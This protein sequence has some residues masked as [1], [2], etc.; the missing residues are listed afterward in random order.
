[1]LDV[2]GGLYPL[3]AAGHLPHN[4]A[5]RGKAERGIAPQPAAATF[6]PQAGRR[7]MPR[8]LAPSSGR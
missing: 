6:S 3:W 8:P 5:V 1:M 2:V 7:D 4:L